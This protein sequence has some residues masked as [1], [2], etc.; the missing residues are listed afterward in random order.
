MN[1]VK[2]CSIIMDLVHKLVKENDSDSIELLKFL[3]KDDKSLYKS[4]EIMTE[5]TPI[6]NLL[7]Y[8]KMGDMEINSLDLVE[9]YRKSFEDIYDHVG[10]NHKDNYEYPLDIFVDKFWNI[11]DESVYFADLEEDYDG[12]YCQEYIVG[13]SIYEGE[14][15]TM[16]L[17]DCQES[18]RRYNFCL[19]LNKN[20]LDYLPD[21]V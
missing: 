6:A 11:E 17:T 7:G 15:Y 9:K 5:P 8:D 14:K 4:I 10:F 3:T 20:R 21:G 1:K 12:N 19:F 18:G 13:N 2:Q 16:V